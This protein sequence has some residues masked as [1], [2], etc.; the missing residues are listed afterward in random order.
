MATPQ[1]FKAAA[2]PAEKA[3]LNCSGFTVVTSHGAVVAV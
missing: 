1:G 3:K 2:I